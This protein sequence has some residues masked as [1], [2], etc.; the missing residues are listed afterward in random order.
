[1]VEESQPV[2][3]GVFISYSRQEKA[4]VFPFV[5]ALRQAGMPV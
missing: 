1:M 4:R 3:G 2:A 5:E